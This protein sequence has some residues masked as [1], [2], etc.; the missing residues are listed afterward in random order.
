MP[1]CVAISHVVIIYFDDNSFVDGMETFCTDSIDFGQ[2]YADCYS[3]EELPPVILAE[4]ECSCCTHCCADGEG[5]L[6]SGFE[7]NVTLP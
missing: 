3:Q 4:V 7:T 2:F 6:P 1:H 5:C